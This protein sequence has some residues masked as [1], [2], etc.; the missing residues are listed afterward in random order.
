MEFRGMSPRDILDMYNEQA[1]PLQ[2][3]AENG[4]ALDAWEADHQR[5]AS[6]NPYRRDPEQS[7]LADV[8][9]QQNITEL[10][11][12]YADNGDAPADL[13]AAKNVELDMSS[14]EK[15]LEVLNMLT[16][17]TVFG[18]GDVISQ[19]DCA[20]SSLIGAAIMGGGTDGLI[21]LMNSMNQNGRTIDA[22]LEEKG[23]NLYK[24]REKIANGDALTVADMQTLQRDLYQQ[25]DRVD[26]LVGDDPE[27]ISTASERYFLQGSDMHDMMVEQGL[28]IGNIDTNFNGTSN[29]AVLQIGEKG[30]YDPWMRKGGQLTTN[31]DEVADYKTVMRSRVQ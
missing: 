16:Q 21:T 17:N 9:A 24:L 26:K 20:A 14:P 7:F 5:W 8:Q 18:D 22:K 3:S 31:P 29:H 11:G 2:T 27:G 30:I 4:A 13:V 10:W 1:H 28:Q 15:R 6:P 25:L 19:K 23:G 12:H